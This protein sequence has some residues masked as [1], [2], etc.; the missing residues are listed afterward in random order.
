MKRKT[1]PE[2]AEDEPLP[3]TDKD[4][5]NTKYAIGNIS[6][7]QYT[8]KMKRRSCVARKKEEETC[9]DEELRRI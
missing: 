9:V 5:V 7:S 2:E 6:R 1:K 8:A 3:V 4:I